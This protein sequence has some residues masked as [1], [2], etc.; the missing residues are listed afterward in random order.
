MPE[1]AM[2]RSA[3]RAAGTARHKAVVTTYALLLATACCGCGSH[4]VLAESCL[5]L[6]TSCLSMGQLEEL[7][8]LLLRAFSCRHVPLATALAAHWMLGSP[9][10]E[11]PAAM[12]TVYSSLCCC[13]SHSVDVSPSIPRQL[14]KLPPWL[15]LLI[16]PSRCSQVPVKGCLCFC[17]AAAAALQSW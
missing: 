13:C 5:V 6:L 4:D 3:A 11:E 17:R 12:L 10:Q 9:N 15:L 1:E 14:Q 7:T 8:S 2:R 16:E